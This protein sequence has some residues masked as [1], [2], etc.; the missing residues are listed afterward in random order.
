MKTARFAT[1]AG[2]VGAMLAGLAW[3]DDAPTLPP[4]RLAPVE[5][6]SVQPI[7]FEYDKYVSEAAKREL[8]QASPSPSDLPLEVVEG[9]SSPPAAP[10]L[11]QPAT[12]APSVYRPSYRCR[13]CCRRECELGEPWTL[14]PESCSGI[15]A[16]GWLEGGIYA[17]AYGAPDNGPL[18]FET[19]GDGFV[20]NQMWGF[21]G[22]AADT[23]GC[24]LDWGGRV[25]YLFGTDGP[26]MQAFGDQ[27]WDFGWNSSPDYGSAI[28]QA[29]AEV[30]VNDLTIKGGH[31][32]TIIGY[33]VCQ[34]PERFFYTHSYTMFY[35][36]PFTHT[37]V[38]ASYKANDA[39][40]VHAGWTDGWDNGWSNPNGASTLL[41][42]VTLALGEK[43]S[44]AWAGSAGSHGNFGDVVI[45]D[46]GDVYMNS[47]VFEWQLTEKL[48]YVFQHDLGNIWGSDTGNA[49][50]YGI[51]QYLLYAFSERWGTG[52][53][54]EWF[55]DD[56]GQRVIA[57]NAGNYYE[58]TW[59]VNY[60]PH[61]NVILRPELRYDWYEG[62]L[63]GGAPFN[64]GQNRGQF[65]GGFD[66]I[67]TF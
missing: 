6:I 24:G 66:F 5:R 36:E 26:D 35:G 38:L 65:S 25:D 14:F 1:A 64:D 17:N 12:A 57:G 49:E 63:T 15:K 44:I 3:A 42:G 28:P 54:L 32:L 37:G 16:G 19:R 31:F 48:K 29:Y 13:R 30:A 58:A 8:E 47:I 59:G 27:T 21:V 34:A 53:R 67:F 51:N 22:K 43:A 50:W 61:A 45:A 18:G 56:D 4:T 9:A 40:T 52:L 20:M 55:R 62:T 60:K 10:Q 2:M 46:L 39:L 7:A 23:G 33:E 11:D 41:A